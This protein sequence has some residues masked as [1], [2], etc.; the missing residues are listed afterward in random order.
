MREVEAILSLP[1]RTIKS[2]I[3]SGF[4]KPERGPRRQFRFSFQDI[5]VLKA[6]HRLI[7]ERLPRRTLTQAIRALRSALP[8]EMPLAGLRIRS[9]GREVIV[10]EKSRAWE[11]AS[12]QALLAFDVVERG[13]SLTLIERRAPDPTAAVEEWFDEALE[14]ETTDP[15]AASALYRRIIEADAS[16]VSAYVNCG[17]LLHEVRDWPAAEQ[18]YREAI[19]ACD[20]CAILNFNLGVLLE[21]VGRTEEAIAAYQQ[22]LQCDP[23]HDN[24]HYNLARLYEA[25]DRSQH[26][27]RHYNQYRRLSRRIGPRSL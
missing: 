21:D 1:S 11:A 7:A 20:T 27:I 25:T 22:A 8:E 12:G 4:L 6:A 10:Q 23:D 26:A 16:Y 14:L 17:R 15:V 24:S 2:L 19:S 5:V 13:D 3:R 9:S 18:V